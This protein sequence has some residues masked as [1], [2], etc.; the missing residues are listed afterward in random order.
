ML[1]YS[2]RGGWVCVWSA[3]HMLSQFD[4]SGSCGALFTMSCCFPCCFLSLI[5]LAPHFTVDLL[6]LIWSIWVTGTTSRNEVTFTI[7]M[8]L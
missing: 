8:V 3:I 1:G 5:F 7:I 4:I 6:N 2:L